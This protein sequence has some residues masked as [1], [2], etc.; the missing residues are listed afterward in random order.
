MAKIGL[1]ESMSEN[2][3]LNPDTGI[4]R[5]KRFQAHSAPHTKAKRKRGPA[6]IQGR[7]WSAGFE[8]G[9]FNKLLPVE[10][11]L[12]GRLPLTRVFARPDRPTSSLPRATRREHCVVL[13]CFIPSARNTACL[14]APHRSLSLSCAHSDS[15]A[16]F[17][18]LSLAVLHEQ[19][20]RPAFTHIVARLVD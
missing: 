12:P 15:Q 18:N 8:S 2:R 14:L 6:T 9:Q 1:R 16:V 3:L 11:L 7:P 13:L 4:A 5:N 19:R 10:D 20:R 17:G